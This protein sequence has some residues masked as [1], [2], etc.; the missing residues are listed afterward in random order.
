MHNLRKHFIIR[1]IFLIET[2][3]DKVSLVSRH[4]MLRNFSLWKFV[5]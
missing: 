4:K 5:M 3:D 1:A 2:H